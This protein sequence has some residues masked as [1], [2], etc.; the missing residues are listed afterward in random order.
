MVMRRLGWPVAEDPLR[1]PTVAGKEL[2]D[3]GRISTFLIGDV[4]GVVDEGIG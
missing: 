2:V 1:L 3:T 4:F